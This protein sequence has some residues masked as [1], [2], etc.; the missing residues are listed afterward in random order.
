MPK[1]RAESWRTCPPPQTPL[2][3]GAFLDLCTAWLLQEPAAA[4]AAPRLTP[5]SACAFALPDVGGEAIARTRAE[6]R[7]MGSRAC[8][9]CGG[10][11]GKAVV[12]NPWA[13]RHLTLVCETCRSP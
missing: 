9:F 11:E 13:Q 3:R 2:Q 5:A 6:M 1:P 12:A 10:P 8:A 4:E 7:A